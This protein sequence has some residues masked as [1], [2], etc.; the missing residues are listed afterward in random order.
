MNEPD[1]IEAISEKL[2]PLRKFVETFEY[3]FP[4]KKD[5]PDLFT[6]ENFRKF[7]RIAP[8]LTIVF[9]V[10]LIGSIIR[11]FFMLNIQFGEMHAIRYYFYFILETV[12]LL[13]TLIQYL[14]W[15]GAGLVASAMGRSSM[16][17]RA[18]SFLCCLPT[19]KFLC[20]VHINGFIIGNIVRLVWS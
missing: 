1:S 3:F 13:A 8:Y 10:L 6:M 7:A 4:R 14:K 15:L 11:D 20:L 5:A 16:T 9:L 12:L 17:P 2:F 19:I 18:M